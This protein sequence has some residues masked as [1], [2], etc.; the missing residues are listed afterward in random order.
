MMSA[1]PDSWKKLMLNGFDPAAPYKQV[2]SFFLAGRYRVSLAGPSSG[3][4]DYMADY[5]RKTAWLKAIVCS[6][7]FMINMISIIYRRI[8]FTDKR[9]TKR[10]PCGRSETCRDRNGMPRP[11]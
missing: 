8:W 4:K 7:E 3:C 6:L 1:L 10:Q 11:Q 9:Q 2:R 5:R